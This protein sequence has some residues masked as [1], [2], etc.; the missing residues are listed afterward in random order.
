VSTTFEEAKQCPKC[1]KP[2]DDTGSRPTN[3][4]GVKVH[5]IFCRNRVCPWLDTSWI[6]QVNQDGSIPEAYSGHGR[7]QYPK[8]SKEM[9]SR[10]NQGIQSQ[11]DAETRS[12]GGEVSGPNR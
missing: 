12:G 2:G 11:I 5:T 6:V 8:V 7:K 4:R 9:E 3:R 1:G 10:I